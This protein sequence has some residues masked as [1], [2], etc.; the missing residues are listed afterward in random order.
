M[1]PIDF[2]GLSTQRLEDMFEAGTQ[3]LEVMRA[4]QNSKEPMNVSKDILRF[5]DEFK[6]WEHIP[7]GDVF[8]KNSHS[9]FYFHA[10]AKTQDNSGIHDDEHGHF[11]TFMRGHAFPEGVLPVTTEDFDP[12]VEMKKDKFKKNDFVTHI[13]AIAT[14]NTGKPIRLF[15]TN[16]W[17]VADTWV[18][19]EDIIAM[20]D[21]FE[22]D[23]TQPSWAVN[24]WI[25]NMMRFY[26]PQIETL[27][28]E[29]DR[30]IARWQEKYPNRNVYNDKELEVTS[31]LDIDLE[32]QLNAIEVALAERP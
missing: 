30:T 23:H 16:R 11:H 25:S 18:K 24:I 20:L 4:Y 22:I 2:T 28:L 32:Q 6:V 21:N 17:V 14:D 13:I 27:I 12:N 5:S 9:Q 3:V 8:D 7:K 15:T 29:R 1:T 31:L 19:A 26:R 10:H